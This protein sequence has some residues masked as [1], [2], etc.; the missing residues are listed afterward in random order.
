MRGCVLLGQRELS[1][2]RGLLRSHGESTSE[3][4]I[5]GAETCCIFS[6]Q[7]SSSSGGGLLP[8]SSGLSR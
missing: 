6:N 4:S 5:G 2:A 8:C 1:D 7:L 3:L